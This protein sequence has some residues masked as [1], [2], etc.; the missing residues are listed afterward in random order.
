MKSEPKCFLNVQKNLMLSAKKI[1]YDSESLQ[2][3]Q[4]IDKIYLLIILS[5]RHI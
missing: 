5:L 2:M 3:F 4:V 1:C